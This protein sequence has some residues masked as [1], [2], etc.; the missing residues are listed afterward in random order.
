MIIRRKLKKYNPET[1]CREEYIDDK[2]FCSLQEIKDY[3][4]KNMNTKS[5]YDDVKF[6]FV[7]AD[8]DEEIEV[9]ASWT[10]DTDGFYYVKLKCLF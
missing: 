4:F 3:C 8:T 2:D 7:I 1:K 9:V 6:T 10:Q 5:L